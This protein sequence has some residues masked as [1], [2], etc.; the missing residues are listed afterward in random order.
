FF[1]QAISQKRAG[2]VMMLA[3]AAGQ[4]SMEDRSI[5]TG[6][7]LFTYYLVDGLNG[8]AD[9][10]GNKDD[11]VSVAEIQKYV[12]E[13]VPAV[14]KTRFNRVQNPYFCCYDK[15]DEIVSIVDPA[16]LKKWEELKL[17]QSGGG[18]SFP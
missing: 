4:E 16:Y 6:H 15:S 1:N 3:T 11:K 5:G 8:I 17:Q 13:K 7:G 18:N 2:E 14:A 10:E 9:S 12:D